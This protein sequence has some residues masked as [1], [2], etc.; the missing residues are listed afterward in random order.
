MLTQNYYK[1]KIK[2]NIAIPSCR[3]QCMNKTYA[4]ICVAPYSM[5][6]VYVVVSTFAHSIF[7]GSPSKEG[8]H[9]TPLDPPLCHT[10][11]TLSDKLK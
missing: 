9:G 4:L 1:K 2:K 10:P 11:E 5:G 8:T 6:V 7:E 3:E